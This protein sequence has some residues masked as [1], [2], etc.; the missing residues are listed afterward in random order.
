MSIF[1]DL[2]PFAHN[3]RNV[4]DLTRTS[5]F[6]SKSG[7]I[8]PCFVQETIPDAKYK[9]DVNGIIRT[10]PMQSANFT[11][12]KA[13]MEFF[14]IP[15]SQLWHY[16]NQFYYGRGDQHRSPSGS[17]ALDA[18][19]INL[20]T[21]D[22]RFIC[23]TL[24]QESIHQLYYEEMIKYLRHLDTFDPLSFDIKDLPAGVT[25]TDEDM[26]VTWENYR[27]NVYQVIN[28]MI[29]NHFYTAAEDVYSLDSQEFCLDIHER[30]CVLDGVR[31][32]DLLGYG[33]L[34]PFIKTYWS[35]LSIDYHIQS[36]YETQYEFKVEQNSLGH[37]DIVV[38]P[39][40]QVNWNDTTDTM[41][42]IFVLDELDIAHGEPSLGDITT[43][44]SH[45]HSQIVHVVSNN[46]GLPLNDYIPQIYPNPFRLMAFFKIWADFYRNA[47][48]DNIPYH[49]LFNCDYLTNPVG[50]NTFAAQ[51]VLRMLVPNYHQYKKDRF[52]GSYPD[53]QFGDIAVAGLNNPSTI[54]I[55]PSMIDGGGA[56]TP[57]LGVSKSDSKLFVK[58]GGITEHKNWIVDTGISVLAI[59]QAEALQR[60]KEKI[61]RAGNREKDLQD[62]IFGVKS[63]Y[64]ED[65][66]V[67]FLGSCDGTININPVA[68]T[69]STDKADIG[70][71]G[72]FAVGTIQGQEMTYESKDF[73]IIIGV[74]YV[75][76]ETKYDAFGIDPFNTKVLPDDFYKPDFQNLGLA[77]VFSSDFNIFN[78]IDTVGGV[79]QSNIKILGYLSRYYEYKTAL[80]KVHGEFYGTNP[81][82][83]YLERNSVA[84][85]PL[86]QSQFPFQQALNMQQSGSLSSLVSVRDVR[87]FEAMTLQALYCSPND[88][89][90]LF[91]Q[92]SDGSLLSDQFN[93]EVQFTTKAILPMSVEGLPY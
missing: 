74:L 2:K 5:T 36:L 20:P 58:Q 44:D 78:K 63:K 83:N 50:N 60:W 35:C 56:P 22:Y 40:S 51:R 85:I 80:N 61:L 66:Y 45:L 3:N 18:Q 88:V 90:S 10:L 1:K 21:F 27:N 41:C 14:F 29:S 76:P 33:N 32:F 81:F 47:Q 53:S 59:R 82:L 15:Y 91:Y 13:N 84:G 38:H 7:M 43:E 86:G 12:L 48:Y 26:N 65:G 25:F 54:T 70:E 75:M 42:S 62:A 93:Y 9:I 24:V 39:F 73:G 77:P 87:D 64:I 55:T 16:F 52:T 68:A 72:A 31:I 28:K 79:Q 69:A 17:V 89:D 6:S 67:D 30:M 19:P 8:Q 71:L 37:Y 49:H 11:Q 46:H 34:L 92:E 23:D 57:T 4:F